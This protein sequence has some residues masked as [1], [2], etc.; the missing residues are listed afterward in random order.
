MK[1]PRHVAIIMDGNGRWAKKRNLPKIMGHR[2]GVETL[3][4]ITKA[5]IKMGIKYL[6]VYAFSSENWQRPREE[7]RGIFGLLDRFLDTE[8]N[9]FNKNKV[10]LN[11]IGDRDKIEPRLRKKIEQAERDTLKNDKLV[12]NIALSYGGRQEILEAVRNLSQD[13]KKG[14]IKPSEID[15]RVFSDYLYTRDCPDPDLLIRTSGEMRVSNF[16]LWQISYSEIYVTEKL[17]PEFQERDLE[18]AVSEYAKR[19]RRFGK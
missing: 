12:L 10:R 16:L 19:E 5:S 3:K 18:K 8:I 7:V 9:L 17:W 2:E 11:I 13:V 4:K 1:I 6:T 15:E 14:N